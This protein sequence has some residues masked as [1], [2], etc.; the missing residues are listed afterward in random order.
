MILDHICYQWNLA[1]LA[2]PT[3]TQKKLMTKYH[4]YIFDDNEHDTLFI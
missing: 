2:N 1:Y 4:Y 3:S